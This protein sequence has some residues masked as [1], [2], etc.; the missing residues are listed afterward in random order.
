MLSEHLI[1]Q[2]VTISDVARIPSESDLFR[3]KINDDDLRKHVLDR[4]KL[5]K[6]SALYGSVFI[7]RDLTFNQRQDLK[8]RRAAA[9][10]SQG[11]LGAE[12]A[13]PG[14]FRN[15][16]SNPEVLLASDATPTQSPQVPV[17]PTL[18]APQPAQ[19]SD[20]GLQ[21]PDVRAETTPKQ[22]IQSSNE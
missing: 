17:S 3:G 5:L 6:T 21:N 4:A 20:S 1:G 2:K 16:G 12:S 9:A 18:P 14:H 8:A 10:T 15:V 22:V 13:G 7:H 11:S 19:S